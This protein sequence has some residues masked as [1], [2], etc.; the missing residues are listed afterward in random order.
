MKIYKK[1]IYTISIILILIFSSYLFYKKF[2]INTSEEA[3]NKLYYAQQ[4]FYQGFIEK[5]LNNDNNFLGFSGICSKYPNTKAGNISKF[6][7][8]ICYYKL[9][10]YDKCIKIMNKFITDDIIISSIR[11]G[12]IGDAFSQMN[13]NKKAI[14]YYIKAAKIGNNDVIT[15][16]YYYK[17]SILNIYL[18]KYK[19]A[20]IFLEKIKKYYPNFFQKKIDKYLAFV[21]E[22]K[23]LSSL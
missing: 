7:S 1:T 9:G 12:L 13:K 23:K 15:P 16:F 6:Y 19:N 22:N 5:S 20:K 11:Y 4:Y 17:I 3:L 10:N 14:K 18:K 8:G 21:S 2:F